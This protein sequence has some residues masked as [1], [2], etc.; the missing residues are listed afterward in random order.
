MNLLPTLEEF[1]AAHG[2][3]TQQPRIIRPFHRRIFQAI[4]RWV[5]GELPDGRRNLAICI[6][7]RHGKTYIARDLV[8]CG[9]MCFPDSEWIYTSCSATLAVAQT[10]AIKEC[11]ASDWYRRA[12]PYVGVETGRGRQ[13][14]FRT[15]C[16]GAVYGVGTEGSLTGFGAGRKRMEFGGGIVID[17]PLVAMDALTI[18]REKCNLWYSQAL[19]S[20]RN[21]AHTPVLLIMQRLHEMDLVGYVQEV[22]GDLWHVLSLPVMDEAGDM[23]WPETFSSDSAL[24]MQKID[25]FAFSAQYMQAPTPAGGAMIKRDWIQSYAASP[26]KIVRYG[27]FTDTAQKTGQQNDYTVFLCAGTDG[28]NVYVLDLVRD[29][30]EA[31]D[32]IDTAKQ[33]WKRH[34]PNRISNPA[35]FIGFFIEDK[36]S[37]T[38]L[39]QTLRRETNI[40]VMPVSR[41]RDKVSRVND[42]LPYVRAGRLHVPEHASW[43]RDYI[44]ELV[45]FSPA[46]THLHDDQVDPTCDAV[47]ELL[48]PGGGLIRNA[49]WS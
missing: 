8:A 31:P 25:P 20:R 35:R 5:A 6:P 29:R 33:F 3:M 10:M 21:A 13:D 49:D 9:L 42:I 17:D 39:I 32:L 23:L 4:T 15:A 45:S 27:I 7:P 14:Y 26:P 37:G 46:M 18:R 44:A 12:A 28:N 40:P 1:F 16:G 38:G 22:E 48:S 43:V 41:D 2:V 34:Q 36:V 47:N 19:Y 30:L 24:R 11:C